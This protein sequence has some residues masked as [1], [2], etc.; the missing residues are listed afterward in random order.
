MGWMHPGRSACVLRRGGR[1]MTH[2]GGLI[3][4]AAHQTVFHVEEPDKLPLAL[5]NA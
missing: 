2:R 3:M 1:M 4:R 5:A